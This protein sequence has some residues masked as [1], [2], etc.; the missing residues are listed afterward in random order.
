V[1]GYAEQ[2]I[3]DLLEV[4]RGN[5]SEDELKWSFNDKKF[6]HS[7]KD[8]VVSD[9]SDLRIEYL[10]SDFIN[11]YDALGLETSRGCIFK[12]K[13]CT[14]PLLGKKKLD[15]L[16]DP[17]TIKDE[18]QANYDKWGTTRYIMA[19]DTFN[20]SI[21]KLQ[22]IERSLSKLP[23]KI[24]FV[25]YARLDLIMAK[26]ESVEILKNIGLRGV[27]FGIETFS[28][29]A[30]RI[31]GKPTNIEKVK[32]GLLW[33]KS[34]TPN[35][36]TNASMIVGLPEDETDPWENLQWYKNSNLDFYTFN[37]L[38]LVDINK[39]V[40]S[41]EFSKNYQSYGFVIMSDEEILKE[42]EIDN[43]DVNDFAIYKQQGHKNKIIYWKNTITGQ[44]Y[45]QLSRL[46]VEMTKTM[47]KRR[48]PC[49]SVFDYASLGYSIDECRTW[50]WYDVIPHVPVDELK[51]KAQEKISAYK[52]RKINYDYESYYKSVKKRYPKV[53]L[54]Q[55]DNRG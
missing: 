55:K 42:F 52:R 25:T 14:Y 13:F 15:Y 46:C 22:A 37:P 36:T 9:T 32:D 51:I 3:L 23:F 43:K 26:P 53:F 10:E 7:N 11:S 4:F 29:K 2:S 30:A 21:H 8:Y 24:E 47:R 35:I 39:A 19:E 50:G 54:N 38:Y 49:W 6:L 18:L 1:D 16:R 17:E 27:H 40:H 45:F 41:S 44:N 28:S 20:D 34:L 5:K 33:W 48:I 31:I 12:C